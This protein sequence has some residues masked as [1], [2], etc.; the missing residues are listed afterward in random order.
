MAKKNLTKDSF[1]KYLNERFGEKTGTHMRK[2][3]PIQFS[4]EYNQRCR[5]LENYKRKGRM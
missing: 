5:N 2:N 1:E 4:V 3:D